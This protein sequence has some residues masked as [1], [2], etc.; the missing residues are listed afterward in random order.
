MRQTEQIPPVWIRSEAT[1]AAALTQPSV[2]LP[3]S[4][5]LRQRE[6]EEAVSCCSR[7]SSAVPPPS[8]AQRDDATP[9]G[10]GVRR[11]TMETE[12]ACA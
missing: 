8:S 5:D 12:T 2:S 1:Y 7:F 4:A 3:S 11:A 6:I 10:L 9:P